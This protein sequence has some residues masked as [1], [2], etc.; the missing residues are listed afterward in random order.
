M[1]IPKRKWIF[2]KIAEAYRAAEDIEGESDSFSDAFNDAQFIQNT[3][4][5]L[6][7]ELTKLLNELHN[8]LKNIQ[9]GYGVDHEK[10]EL[11]LYALED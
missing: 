8:F 10:L 2:D 11:L 7:T 6:D 3:L 1:M 9:E 4:N 5:E